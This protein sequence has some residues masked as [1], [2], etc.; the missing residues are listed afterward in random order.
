MSQAPN[1]FRQMYDGKSRVRVMWHGAMAYEHW[2]PKAAPDCRH[3]KVAVCITGQISRL[4]VNSKKKNVLTPLA[5]ALGSKKNVDLFLVME[6]ESDFFVN[7]FSIAS[8]DPVCHEDVMSPEALQATFKDHYKGG[9]YIAHQDYAPNLKMWPMYGKE[10]HNN[11]TRRLSGHLSQ[12]THLH[13]CAELI[14]EA[15]AKHGCP[16][17]HVLKLRDNT[18][19]TK[20]LHIPRELNAILFKNCSSWDGFNDKVMIT[21]RPYMLYALQGPLWLAKQVE[22]G[23]PESVE[24]VKRIINPE[25]FMKVVMLKLSVPVQ[26]GWLDLVDGRCIAPGDAGGRRFCLVPSWKDCHTDDGKF[27]DCPGSMTS[28]EFQDKL[29]RQRMLKPVFVKGRPQ[30]PEEDA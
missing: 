4:E 22:D 9:L 3:E 10:K 27:Q 29:R 21:P 2:A 24:L 7:S 19:A 25:Q 6:K 8:K 15:E 1:L 13:S 18:I 12:W 30:P 17:N 5:R 14:Q 11:R 23:K 20:P 28:V 16:Y 26:T